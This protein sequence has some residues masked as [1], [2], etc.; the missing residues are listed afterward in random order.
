M[1][2]RIW[3]RGLRCR[4]FVGIEDW[5]QRD[6]QEIRID[7]E[8]FTDIGEAGRSDRIEQTVNYRRVSKATLALVEGERFQ[9]VERLAESVAAMILKE[10]AS[11]RRVRLS[12]EKPGAL[13]FAESVGV[14]IE[15]GR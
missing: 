2:D 4:A 1:D 3:I 13:R 14:R 6:R 12:V 8:L 5:E 15:R 7:I 11:V 10:F 9:L